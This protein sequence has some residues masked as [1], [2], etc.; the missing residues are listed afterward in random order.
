MPTKTPDSSR[1]DPTLRALA[2]AVDHVN[3]GRN[4]EAEQLA[5]QV[6]QS[7]PDDPSSLNV[8]GVVAMRRDDLTEAAAFFRRAL[9][10]QPGNPFIRFNLAETHRLGQAHGD[11]LSQYSAAIRLKPD[12][13]EAH[14][15][16]GEVLRD[17]GRPAEAL[18]AFRRALELQPGLVTALH[19]IG[20]LLEGSGEFEEAA[21]HYEAAVSEKLVG[22]PNVVAAVFANTGIA[23]LRRGAAIEGFA[24][25][26][27]A[28]KRD[29]ASADFPRL[30]AQ[31]L[32]NTKVVPDDAVFREVLLS[33]LQREDID[34]TALATAV[35]LLL[36]AEESNR[37]VL[38][39]ARFAADEGTD[40]DLKD[41]ALW[42]LLRNPLLLALLPNAPIPDEEIELLLTA[43]RRPLL[44]SGLTG[45]FKL[46]HQAGLPFLAALAQQCFLNEY[47]Y[48]Q[49]QD[50]SAAV[51]AL[52]SAHGTENR[53]DE[54]VR[55]AILAC[56]A[57]LCEWLSPEAALDGAPAEFA[58]LRRQQLD[59]PAHEAVLTAELKASN[60]TREPAS[61]PPGGEVELAAPRWSRSFVGDPRPFR[62]RIA[63]N[64]PH[65]GPH[66]APA[67]RA[68]KILILGCRTGRSVLAAV[69][70]YQGASVT[71]AER[72][73]RSL[74]YAKRK[75]LEH[76]CGQVDLIWGDV[77]QLPEMEQQFD[78]IEAPFAFEDRATTEASLAVAA[79][80]LKPG[81][82]IRFGLYS[83]TARAS[84]RKIHEVTRLSNT[85]RTAEGLRNL[86][87]DLMLNPIASGFDI[88]KNPA[89]DFWSMSQCLELLLQPNEARFELPEISDLLVR[90][91]L[92]FLG[93]ELGLG[94]D[95][96]RFAAEHPGP[97]A[98]SD[99]AVWAQFENSHPDVFGDGYRVWARRRLGRR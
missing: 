68:P 8:L 25:L 71:A 21:R 22:E 34:P 98:P 77:R 18:V 26:T 42:S 88:L 54:W 47:V 99:L 5:R 64:L 2:E 35:V 82:F 65:L 78:L 7:R 95:R 44:L 83:E 16:C 10:G 55:L 45:D 37:K 13:A 61:Y 60:L 20:R 33:L 49:G 79:R 41:P 30:L 67:L 85:N 86:R 40:F 1:L 39:R 28:V 57:P 93:L 29:P 87:R 24:A 9:R 32:R 38:E 17:K 50:E 58:L 63:E 48:Y 14:A 43:V 52:M 90:L 96:A 81:G 6:L 76:G 3:A 23:R 53:D 66:E 36:K 72:G 11:A 51:A 80:W 74:A 62:T 70:S 31:S 15:R 75:L 19:G 46:H 69:S 89:S 84:V 4:E 27:E 56:F 97:D 12:F 59:E 94:F 92:D 73:L 91:R